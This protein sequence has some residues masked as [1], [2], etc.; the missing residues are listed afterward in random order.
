[1]TMPLSEDCLDKILDRLPSL[2]IGL[3]GDLFLDRYFELDPDRQEYS[4][5]T[6]LEAYQVQQVRNQPGA[7]GTI[8][9][10]LAALGVGKLIPL[11]VIGDDG[12]GK[13]LIRSLRSLPVESQG[14]LQTSSRLTPTY[15]KPIRRDANSNPSELNRLDIRS[16]VPMDAESANKVCEHLRNRFSDVDGWIVL[17]QI[18]AAEEGVVNAQIRKTLDA[19]TKET[20]DMPVVIDSRSH[21]GEFHCGSLKGNQHEF[22]RATKD[23]RPESATRLLASKTN[24]PA[25][26]TCGDS[27]IWVGLPDGTSSLATPFS[28]QSP[29][30]I[31]GAGDA[32]T[33][34]VLSGL[35]GNVSPIEAASFA[36][37]VA[38]ITVEQCGTTGT[39][40]PDQVR[41]RHR[42]RLN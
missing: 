31:V 34:A 36:N 32:A 7:L 9:S 1:M 35:L 17:D 3:L 41:A 26:C 27:G 10:N 11:T 33:A 22:T 13:D 20:P 29:I 5:E 14:I 37:L 19:L 21:L 40:T 12:L 38:S 28:V 39:A 23:S 4:I 30:D 18:D 6:E 8:M 24:R 15:I 25:F 16:R 42:R 2:R